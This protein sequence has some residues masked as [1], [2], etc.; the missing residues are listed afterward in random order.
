MDVNQNSFIN[1]AVWAQS[2]VP[3]NSYPADVFLYKPNVFFQFENVINDL[4][5]KHVYNICKRWSNLFDV[6]LTIS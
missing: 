6:G 2:C 5:S 3:F 4:P 1:V